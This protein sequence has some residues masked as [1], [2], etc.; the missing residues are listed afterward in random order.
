LKPIFIPLVASLLVSACVV[1]TY[2][3]YL[4]TESRLAVEG[5]VCGTVPYGDASIP[6][7][8]TLR[9]YVSVT[10]SEQ[11][12]A[13]LIQLSLPLGT[14]VRFLRPELG[15][16]TPGAKQVHSSPLEPFRISV[17]GEGGRPGHHEFV[18]PSA[19]LEGKGRNL[20]LA[21]TDT[22]YLK[23]DLFTSHTSVTVAPTDMVV[24]LFPSIEVNRALIEP[25]RIPLHLVKKTGVLTCVQ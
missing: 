3:Y 18:A 1:R 21:T 4:P 19:L 15:I 5:T 13:L 6:L 16:E 10:P 8:E 2:Q 11:S 23:S 22:Q 25:Q 17:Y 7:G 14:K 12:I 20:R 24:L 9:A